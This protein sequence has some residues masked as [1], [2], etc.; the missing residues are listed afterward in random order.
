MRMKVPPQCL[1]LISR[2]LKSSGFIGKVSPEDPDKLASHYLNEKRLNEQIDLMEKYGPIRGN[3]LEIGS[4][5]G[6]LIT[7]LNIGKGDNCQAYGL[8]PSA[9]AYTGTLTCTKILSRANQV[10]NRF[11]SAW[12]EQIP[13]A[14]GT[15][16]WVYS[17]SVLEHVK[18][19]EQVISESMRVLKPGGLL[20][21]VVPNYGSWWEGHYGILMLPGMPKFLF[22]RYVSLLGRDPDFVDTLQFISKKKLKRILGS[23]SDEVEILSW[24]ERLFEHRLQHIDF[25]EWASL[26]KLMVWVKLLHRLGLVNMGI[27]L[28]RL[29][30]WETPVVMTL[31]K[32]II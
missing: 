23:H 16:D 32:K 19:P 3:F 22:K 20:Q 26:G 21:F 7:Y 15:F 12:G 1:N 25:S 6:G 17:T 11:V 27:R 8:E 9:D 5:F 24:G 31:K 2:S 29:L 14:S 4:G 30:E 10:S 18:D 13:F 28:C